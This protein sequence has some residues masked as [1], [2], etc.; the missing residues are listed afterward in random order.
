MISD[1][2]ADHG[3]CLAARGLSISKNRSIEAL[4][5]TGDYRLNCQ[6]VNLTIIRRFIKDLIIV[7]LA[8]GTTSAE[9]TADLNSVLSDELDAVLLFLS[10]YQKYIN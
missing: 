5:H 3:M 1:I 10:I 9:G 8:I 7:E 6:L 4:H 2:L